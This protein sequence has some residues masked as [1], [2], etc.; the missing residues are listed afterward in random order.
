MPP[1]PPEP[2]DPP[3]PP[4]PPLPPVPPVPPEPLV[5]VVVVVLGLEV[6]PPQETIPAASARVSVITRKPRMTIAALSSLRRLMAS[7]VMEIRQNAAKARLATIGLPYI[8]RLREG[9]AEMNMLLVGVPIR[10]NVSVSVIPCAVLSGCGLN[11][12][13]S[14]LGSWPFDFASVFTQENVIGP[15]KPVLLTVMLTF[16]LVVVGVR[17]TVVG[18]SEPVGKAVVAKSMSATALP[19]A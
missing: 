5:P 10:V 13:V 7:I 16:A 8:G 12:H 1:L 18:E 4:V 19:L 3:E 11:M 9:G 14:Q 15:E 17:F 6:L 2:P